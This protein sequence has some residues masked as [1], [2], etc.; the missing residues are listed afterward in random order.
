MKIINRV[1]FQRCAILSC[2][3][4]VVAY[5]LPCECVGDNAMVFTL[6]KSLCD[7]FSLIKD[8]VKQVQ[9]KHTSFIMGGFLN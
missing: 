3:I 6:C 8:P 4:T 1:S 2:Q 5:L 9:L 7:T